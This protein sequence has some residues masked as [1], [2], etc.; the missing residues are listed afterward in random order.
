MRRSSTTAAAEPPR[1]V[2]KT[3]SN[4]PN[5]PSNSAKPLTLGRFATGFAAVG[6]VAGVG[7]TA[8]VGAGSGVGS[9]AIGCGSGSAG[10]SG[11]TGGSASVLDSGVASIGTGAS[12]G[13]GAA[14]DVERKSVA[15]TSRVLG[16]YEVVVRNARH[17]PRPVL[18]RRDGLEDRH[19]R[20]RRGTRRGG[21]VAVRLLPVDGVRLLL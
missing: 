10:T 7:A 20:G 21:G 5:C 12:V 17:A 15:A 1:I 8:G 11:S 13:A 2:V 3:P 14:D 18:D 16:R 6:V 9:G 19:S 4:R